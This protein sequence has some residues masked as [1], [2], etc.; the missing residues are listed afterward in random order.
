[1][2][3]ATTGADAERHDDGARKVEE[4]K[5]TGAKVEEEE[6]DA[7]SDTVVGGGGGGG[8]T[9]KSFTF[10]V[11]HMPKAEWYTSDSGGRVST[12]PPQYFPYLF[13]RHDGDAGRLCLSSLRWV[14]P[15][16]QLVNDCGHTGLVGMIVKAYNHHIPLVI[17][18]S[19]VMIAALTQLSFLINA[20]AAT[21]KSRVVGGTSQGGKH[22]VHVAVNSAGEGLVALRAAV[23]GAIKD[24]KLAEAA[25]PDFSDAT[26][27]DRMVAA[28]TF[29][30]MVQPFFDY[31]MTL[32]CGIPSITVTGSCADWERLEAK[33]AALFAYFPL[34]D[35]AEYAAWQPRMVTLVRACRAARAGKPDVEYWRRMVTRTLRGSGEPFVS[36]WIGPT[37][38]PFQADGRPT[39]MVPHADD[40]DTARV[41]LCDISCAGIVRFP[42][43]I[44]HG[45]GAAPRKYEMVAG[46]VSGDVSDGRMR[47][48]S[49][50]AVVDEREWEEEEQGC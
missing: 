32:M 21:L 13:P 17:Q 5:D 16:A 8:G 12:L 33:L 15:S 49:A 36:G 38:S 1:M 42:V 19:K 22:E 6:E 2:S 47:P 26:E 14:P 50:W 4:G 41:M 20:H 45:P 29:L 39:R 27:T 30:G 37:L 25:T 23:K 3:V 48:L 44:A 46:I 18:P 9:V 43:T 10:D 28:A 24:P 11:V 35:V 40:P 7:T 31:G 34:P